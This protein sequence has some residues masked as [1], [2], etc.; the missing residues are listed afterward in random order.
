MDTYILFHNNTKFPV[1]V[2]S[3]VEDSRRL[4]SL[5]VNP[6][7]K[8]VILSCIGEWYMD[9]MFED[10]SDRKIWRENGFGHY[11][12]IGKFRSTPNIHG[13]YSWME[14]DGDFSCLFVPSQ[15][16][17]NKIQGKMIFL[18]KK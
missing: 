14:Y 5:K 3:W 4:N 16:T 17:E 1:N 6:G 2:N 8:R 9:T 11:F 18:E 10:I 7:E 13:I 12:T 15:N